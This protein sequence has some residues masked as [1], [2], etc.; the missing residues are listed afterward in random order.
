MSSNATRERY[1]TSLS[2]RLPPPARPVIIIPGFGHSRLYDP[3]TRRFVWGTGR[4]TLTARFEDDFD[5]PRL[6]DGTI[7]RDRLEPRGFVG[8]RGPIN[9]AWQLS[10]AL[11]R[12]ARYEPGNEEPTQKSNLYLFSYD[13]RLSH[14]DSAHRLDE[15]IEK[16]RSAH[17]NRAMSV[18][19][20]THS[21]GGLVALAYLRFGTSTLDAPLAQRL[22]SSSAAMQKIRSIVMLAPPLGG[23]VEA[24]RLLND[25]E[26]FGRR[27]IGP[28]TSATFPSVPELFPRD[29]RLF[30]DAAG[31]PLADDVWATDTWSKLRL[32]IFASRSDDAMQRAFGDLVDRG[33]RFRDA[34]DTL[35]ADDLRN[36]HVIAGDCV[37]TAR[38]VV[39]TGNG[40]LRFYPREL[41]A[42][43]LERHR[44]TLFTEGDGSVTV[45]SASALPVSPPELFCS[46]H[47]ALALD[48]SVYRA[49]IR[50]LVKNGGEPAPGRF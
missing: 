44:R 24:I 32:S 31:T 10:D 49:I 26:K 27:R 50:A 19:L 20:V 39:I 8:S 34:I 4:S 43:F 22:Q 28:E 9:S 38:R 12:F 37:E 5:L 23:S 13:W 42:A 45:E 1:L 41:E 21:D 11:H 18:D 29:G 15:F 16:V 46:G 35:T 48:P 6:P 2:D 30:V 3:V 36:V 47:H 7:G 14:V 40:S 33:R 17:G 25:E